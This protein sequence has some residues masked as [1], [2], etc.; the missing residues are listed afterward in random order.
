[1]EMT[2]VG[3]AA[4][5][6]FAF[7]L[8]QSLWA[9][10]I[11]RLSDFYKTTRPSWSRFLHFAGEPEIVF[12][13]WAGIFLIILMIMEGF[14]AG[15]H[16]MDELNF[17]EVAFV[18]V[19]M[20]LASSKPVTDF[21]EMIISGLSKALPF[22]PGVRI[23]AT[24][25][26]VGP[27]LGSLITEPAAMT[28]SAI[29]LKRSVFKPLAGKISERLFYSTLAV[30]FVNISIGGT[31]THFAAPPVLMVARPWGWDTEFMFMNFGWKAVIAALLNTSLAV[32]VN[33][34]T[35]NSIKKVSGVVHAPAKRAPGWIMFVHLLFI[36]VCVLSVHHPA[37]V[38]GLFVFFL[39]FYAITKED[40]S[41]VRV[42][43]SMLVGFFLGGLVI[44]TAKQGWWLKPILSSVE[45]IQLYIGTLFLAPV[46]DNAAITS[47]ASQV[48]NL[49]DGSKYLIVS[50]AVVGG[51][52]T[53]IANAPNP[54]GFALLRAYCPGKS[55]RPLG[56]LKAALLPT[57]IAGAVFWFL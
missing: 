9:S 34:T 17:S 21:A 35:L 11:L 29:L 39:G 45:N 46:T 54:A 12:G 27:L 18:F 6:C 53:I 2:A 50:A 25:L 33:K 24:I 38:L 16:W 3:L 30:L 28:I 47:L 57:I 14:S 23:Y 52:M 15:L 43:E 32:Y 36:T 5:I 40:Q 8:L 44:L 10:K 37:F 56:L 1:M 49:S 48:S 42:E 19:I 31:L 51:G 7:A 55:L 26:F 13:I 22:S 41:D 4:T 20:I